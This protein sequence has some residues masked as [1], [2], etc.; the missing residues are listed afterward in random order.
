VTLF[1]LIPIAYAQTNANPC[2]SLGP[3]STLCNLGSDQFGFVVS[4]IITII[5]ILTVIISV[6]YFMY[7]GIKWILSR[8]DKEK[9]EEAK[10]QIIAS[11][12]GLIMVFLAF[13][14][15]NI[16]FGFFFPGKSLKDLSLPSLGPDTKPP[17]VSISSPA[18]DSTVMGIAAI[19]VNATDNKEVA[20]VEFYAD[21]ILKNTDTK[22]PFEY[23][24][25]TRLYKHNS[26]HT[27]SARAYDSAK[28]VGNSASVNV[29]VIDVTKPT[30]KIT[31]PTN[32]AKLSSGN[33]LNISSLATDISSVTQ[34][35]F[36]I[37][38]ITKCI[39]Y[40]A[41]YACIWQ[42]PATKGVIYRIE[43]SALD[44][45]GNSGNTSISIE[46]M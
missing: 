27:I 18:S 22:E 16:V 6:F 11:L 26:A 9:I 4:T 24:W 46:T 38:G 20:K 2:I 23:G 13:F 1:S 43:S 32:N 31:Y 7:G 14:V 21:G 19:Q 28:N 44:I 41:P 36:K 35:E 15:I 10:N 30:L 3:F 33:T 42:I 29:V 8:G 40:T 5:L 12:A 45:A 17:V 25:D 39:D 34:V 37:N